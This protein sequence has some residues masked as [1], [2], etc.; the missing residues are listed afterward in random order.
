MRR[1]EPWMR[2]GAAVIA[3]G[4]PA[5]ISSMQENTIQGIEYV[6]YIMAKLDGAKTA[7]T[8]HPNDITEIKAPGS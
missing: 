4:K 1:K 2:K 7:G 5:T 8:Y 6:Y 3:L